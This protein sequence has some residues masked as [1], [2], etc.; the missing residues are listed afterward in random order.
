MS[1]LTVALLALSI[2]V[3]ALGAVYRRTRAKSLP[4]MS[5]DDFLSDFLN[6]HP[7][8]APPNVILA[9][10]RRV[11]RVLGIPPE[12]LTADQSEQLLSERLSFFVHFSVAWNDLVDEAAEA[13]QASG[14]G[15]RARPPLTVG[16]VIEDRLA[17]AQ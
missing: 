7:V 10:R 16:E 3:A 8:T 4:S 5:D 12:R 13:R 17:T 1:G 9:E 2:G 15:P 6:R 14:L 11:A